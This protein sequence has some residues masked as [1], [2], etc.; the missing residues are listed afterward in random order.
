MDA[1]FD[2]DEGWILAKETSTSKTFYKIDAETG[3]LHLK[4]D[5]ETS[6]N[7][8]DCTCVWKEVGLY[9]KWFP[10]MSESE[11]LHK[12]SATDMVL[13]TYVGLMGIGRELLLH[14]Y[15]DCSNL[16]D[17]QSFILMAK[18]ITDGEHAK[19][20]PDFNGIPMPNK[21]FWTRRADVTALQML[22]K[23]LGT[24]EETGKDRVRNCMILAVDVKM[25]AIP[26][27][28]LQALMK[29][30]AGLIMSVF[31]STAQKLNKPGN[32]H[33]EQMK[34][35]QWYS[36]TLFPYLQETGAIQGLKFPSWY[37]PRPEAVAERG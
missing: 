17:E 29:Q 28:L 36:E 35:D 14:G 10:L 3:L 21:S 5:G 25:N 31:D 19:Q 34:A 23:H 16:K 26:D 11:I 33:M 32:V 22:V 15:G 6:A 20:T 1:G 24:D 4:I 2:S 30:C 12:F 8:L 18:S 27:S 9:K 7:M 13:K 37:S